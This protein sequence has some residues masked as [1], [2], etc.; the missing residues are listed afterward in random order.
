[1]ASSSLAHWSWGRE[2]LLG[3]ALHGDVGRDPQF[4]SRIGAGGAEANCGARRSPPT[5]PRPCSTAPLRSRRRSVRGSL[6]SPLSATA[7]LNFGARH[8]RTSWSVRSVPASRS[9][10]R[11]SCSRSL[12]G[13]GPCGSPPKTRRKC[14]IGQ[15]LLLGQIL[16]SEG[17]TNYGCN[18]SG[19]TTPRS[20]W[21]RRLHPVKNVEGRG[22]RAGGQAGKIGM[23]RLMG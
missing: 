4:A 1:M 8:E 20:R 23:V 5:R 13:F 10:S 19:R 7:L 11:T 18:T 17:G 22:G 9:T 21:S 14:S 2:A 12:A 3:L 16:S 15:D 6:G